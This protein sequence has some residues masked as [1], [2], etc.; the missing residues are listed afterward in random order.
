MLNNASLLQPYLKNVKSQHIL[1]FYV[2]IK[3]VY[4]TYSDVPGRIIWIYNIFSCSRIKGNA[5]ILYPQNNIVAFMDNTNVYLM[6]F[7]ILGK[8]VLY[9]I[10]GHFLKEE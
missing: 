9:D 8:A 4:H 5:V 6:I 7:P 2:V 10:T 1:V 3:L